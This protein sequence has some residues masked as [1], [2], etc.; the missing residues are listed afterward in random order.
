[1]CGIAGLLDPSGAPVDK[2]LLLKMVA[3]LAPRGPDGEG[4]WLAPGV[5][6][7]H[8]RLS[9]IDLSEAASQPMGSEDG[10]VQVVFN[11]EIYNFQELRDELR[12]AGY[13]F[14]SR[15]DTEVLVH[16]YED[17]GPEMLHRLNGMFA[18]A[19]WD[20]R[21]RQLLLYRCPI[22]HVPSM[23][24]ECLPMGQCLA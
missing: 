10:L 17:E 16:L 5:G 11:G 2:D 4:I 3:T 15:S 7:G 22:P 19:I 9:V 21:R 1:M 23:R 12:A 8:R 20:S 13:R 18:L 6:L 14:H 24:E